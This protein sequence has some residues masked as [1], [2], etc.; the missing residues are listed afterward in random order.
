M[1]DR[2]I[3]KQGRK[4]RPPDIVYGVHAVREALRAGKRAVRSL[5][6]V[7][8]HRGRRI[9][10]ILGLAGAR[11][12]PVTLTEGSEMTRRFPGREDQG[13]AAR[14]DPYPYGSL[15][16]VLGSPD[17]PRLLVALDEV[18]DPHNLG[19]VIRCAVAF[20]A[21]G[22]ILPANR[23]T[24]VT[25]AVV[26]AS[27]GMTERL[28]VVVVPNLATAIRT[29]KQGGVWV[30]GLD[31]RADRSI[32][33]EDL[34]RDL[35]FVLGSEGKGLRRLTADLCDGLLRIPLSQGCESLNVSAASAVGLAE[36]ARQRRIGSG[37]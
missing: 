36:A 28:T 13:V 12:I 6:V 16:D 26:R 23:S 3:M 25:P 30:F 7:R 20:E 24:L 1:Y 18:Q 9:E 2:K 33:K 21:G 15:D 4:E 14:V 19:A 10:E 22:L 5:T 27:A 31:G 34:T 29:I 11:G 8:N 17:G 35:M 37:D 32:Y